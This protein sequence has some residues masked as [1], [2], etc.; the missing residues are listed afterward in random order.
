MLVGSVEFTLLI[1][2]LI[3]VFGPVVAERFK[4]PGLVGLIAGGM[5]AGP[6][7]LGW[8]VADGLVTELGAIGIL[9]LMFLAGLSFNIKAF[10]QNRNSA[11]AYG[12]LGFII[13]F[14]LSV[15]VV[16]EVLEIGLLG[17]ALIGA[18]WASN[19]LVA[20]PEVRAAGLQNNRAVSAAVS[21]GVVADLLSLTVLALAT[22]TAVIEIEPEPFPFD[23]PDWF[24][25]AWLEGT[26]SPTVPDPTLPL[27]LALPLLVF[28]TLWLLPRIT[29]WFFVRVGRTRMQRFVFLLAGMAA[30]AAVALIGGIEGLIG[31]FLAGLGMNRLI[32]ERGALMGRLDMVGT[33]IFV[34]TFLVSI[35]LSIDPSLLFDLETVGIAAMFTGFVV[36]G[37]G[38]AALITG[39]AFRFNLREIGLMSSL[40]FGQAASTLAIAQ[41]GLQLGMF[42]QQIVNA[43]VLA[44]VFT[45]LLT[46]YGT[47]FFI[48]RVPR[49][50]APPA[51]VGEVVM[52][53][54]R[55]VGPSVDSLLAF[56]GAV[57]FP[58]D[59]LVIPYAIPGRGELEAA[60][61]LVAR[62]EE[63]AST[64]GLDSEGRVRVD[65]SFPDGTLD[66]SEE[67][68]ASMVI[69]SWSGPR[70]TSDFLIGNDIDGVGQRSE[71]PT[72]AA[73]VL[74]PWSRIVLATGQMD[75]DWHVE[76]GELAM[77]IV[78]RLRRVEPWP[79]AVLTP[80]AG[81][82]D[83]KIGPEEGIEMLTHEGRV[84]EMVRD[85]SNDDLVIVPS[86]VLHDL[87]PLVSW[88]TTR[89]LQ[90]INL[91]VVA[92]PHRLSL[93]RGAAH[94]PIEAM[95]HAPG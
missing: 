9:M 67:I 48:K 23:L 3:I 21:A 56:A 73:R 12:L 89:E 47:R 39:L 79:V 57:A 88:R 1:L 78:N 13:P 40:S 81:L 24:E 76:D 49:P 2:L 85:L 30:G 91:V 63:V 62:A 7:V 86:Y 92:G 15:A 74:R 93:S 61:E 75:V 42:D 65:E 36:V 35:G 38:A 77:A 90:D 29:E 45:A 72:A 22:A 53:D 32:P 26:V 44:I 41:V 83:G 46:S 20:Y 14:V 80:D 6:F 70:F 18:M 71:V 68:D 10:L 4:I 69:L 84:A 17:A 27:W 66:L 34:P 58:D 25:D 54:V 16:V 55:E 52:V 28:F 11:V 43:A 33:W 5:L 19:T 94:Q 87:S 60:K 50:V 59:G 31:A 37:K 64:H 8:L 51:E 82:V 95:V